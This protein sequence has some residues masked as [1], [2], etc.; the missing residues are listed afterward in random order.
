MFICVQLP[1]GK[2]SLDL[3]LTVLI[4]MKIEIMFFTC[5]AVPRSK[6]RF[7]ENI[8]T[9]PVLSKSLCLDSHVSFWLFS[10]YICS[11]RLIYYLFI[12][13]L[14]IYLS[15]DR[16]TGYLIFCLVNNELLPKMG[17]RH[18]PL[19]SLKL[20]TANVTADIPIPPA[21]HDN[22]HDV[23]GIFTVFLSDSSDL[24]SSIDITWHFT[25]IEHCL[26][27]SYYIFRNLMA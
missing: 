26:N 24:K 23:W 3:R 15:I 22:T 11:D 27:K 4:A 17:Q 13:D 25:G 9:K 5:I 2:R 19:F 7:G 18:V 12:Y 20:L 21:V 16:S 6:S 14:F 8:L 10:S 1:E